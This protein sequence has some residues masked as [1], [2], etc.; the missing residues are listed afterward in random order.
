MILVPKHD[1][2]IVANEIKIEKKKEMQPNELFVANITINENF[3]QNGIFA[4]G[5]KDGFANPF[6]PTGS[7]PIN[8]HFADALFT[9]KV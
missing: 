3:N 1:C 7:T 6:N 4:Y 9:S 8:I 5:S 2:T